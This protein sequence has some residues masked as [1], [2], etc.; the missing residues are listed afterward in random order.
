[1]CL[2]HSKGAD[3]HGA[4]LSAVWG[5]LAPQG[6]PGAGATACP[7]VLLGT[8]KRG[9]VTPRP[10]GGPA[11]EAEQKRP[12]GS[13]T[14]LLKLALDLKSDLRKDVL[15]AGQEGRRTQSRVRSEAPRLHVLGGDVPKLVTRA[16]P[17]WPSLQEDSQ[18]TVHEQDTLRDQGRPRR[19]DKG[20]PRSGRQG[21]TQVPG[22]P[23][24]Q[25]TRCGG[26][27]AAC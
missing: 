15:Q 21:L 16:V 8:T 5:R 17:A 10:S 27:R 11:V 1:M 24:T 2:H 26:T 20:P 13:E 12:R 14:V 23:L 6:P 3:C 25:T 19:W 9:A 7:R 18:G 4:T 22:R